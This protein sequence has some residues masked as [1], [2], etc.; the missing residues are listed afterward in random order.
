MSAPGIKY[1]PNNKELTPHIAK[2]INH[3]IIVRGGTKR[4]IA[5]RP[6]TPLYFTHK[7]TAIMTC[8]RRVK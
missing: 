1:L 2:A 6:S 4:N 7:H 5:L 8:L 3:P